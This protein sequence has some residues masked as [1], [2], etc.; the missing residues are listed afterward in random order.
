M[1]SDW[2]EAILLVASKHLI[3]GQVAIENEPSADAALF[4]LFAHVGSVS[5]RRFL[6]PATYPRQP[7][8]L[9][10]HLPPLRP[11]LFPRCLPQKPHLPASFAQHQ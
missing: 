5:L 4:A 11:F 1:E 8:R 6:L 2:P 7:I 10:H 9:L 3:G